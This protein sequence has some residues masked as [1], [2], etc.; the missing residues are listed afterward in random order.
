MD[1]RNQQGIIPRESK[2]VTAAM[3]RP[4][5]SPLVQPGYTAK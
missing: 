5:Q 3:A 4:K 2:V 1:S